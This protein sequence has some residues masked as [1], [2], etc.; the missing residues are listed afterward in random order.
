[1][2]GAR[3]H[4]PSLRRERATRDRRPR[5]RRADLRRAPHARSRRP[6]A[7]ARAHGGPRAAG[8]RPRAARPPAAA[9]RDARRPP[10][11]GI[12]AP[13]RGAAP[14]GPLPE[15]VVAGIER[16]G[17]PPEALAIRTLYLARSDPLGL[18]SDE[19]LRLR[20]HLEVAPPGRVAILARI[21]RDDR[22]AGALGHVL[23]RDALGTS[24]F[25]TARGEEQD[26]HPVD[27]RAETTAAQ[28]ECRAVK[29][30]DR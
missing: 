24:A 22:V 15:F 7:H 12:R 8:S 26:G 13:R 25:A 5:R 3:T 29:A 2:D 16:R 19:H 21:G 4:P 1:M 20:V 10:R 30:P 27:P 14:R 6:A 18:A 17:L 11:S 9:A 23:Q 28:A